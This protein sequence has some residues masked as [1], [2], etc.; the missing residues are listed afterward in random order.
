[1]P[2]VYGGSPCSPLTVSC[3]SDIAAAENILSVNATRKQ[4]LKF[5]IIQSM[6]KESI[7][8][9]EIY[10]DRIDLPDLRHVGYIYYVLSLVNFYKKYVAG[11]IY[12]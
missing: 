1:M 3:H 2:T 5:R 7:L 8:H 10:G 9:E 6:Q 12:M 4:E 11:R